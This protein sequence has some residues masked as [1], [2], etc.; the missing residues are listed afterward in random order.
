MRV[1]RIGDDV[2]GRRVAGGATLALDRAPCGGWGRT[3]LGAL[4]L[5][6]AL[7]GGAEAFWRSRGLRPS[8]IDDLD[9]WAFERMRASFA[10]D[11][12][13]LVGD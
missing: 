3:W 8:V 2:R 4:L 10:G 12:I 6:A 7:I 9:L 11:G 13:V 5:A 1:E